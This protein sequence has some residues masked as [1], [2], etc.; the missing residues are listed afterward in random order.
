MNLVTCVQHID[1]IPQRITKDLSTGDLVHLFAANKALMVALGAILAARKAALAAQMAHK[2]TLLKHIAAIKCSFCIIQ[3]SRE[4]RSRIEFNP[5]FYAH[6]DD[7]KQTLIFKYQYIKFHE[8]IALNCGDC[9]VVLAGGPTYCI[10]SYPYKNK[11][12]IMKI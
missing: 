4:Y 12:A 2:K 9:L 7:K 5:N 11:I 6:N 10:Y 8:Y 3:H 1:I